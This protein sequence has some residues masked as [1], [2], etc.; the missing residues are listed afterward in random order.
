M[1][2]QL[3]F[4]A[5][6]VFSAITLSAQVSKGDVE[7]FQKYFGAEKAVM[8]KEYMQL[9]PAQ[10]SAFWPI[11]NKYENQRLALGKQRV[12]LIDTYLKNIEGISEIDAGKLVDKGVSLEIAFKNLQKRYFHEMSKKIGPVKAAQFYQFENYLNNVINLSIQES[13]PFVGDLEQRHDALEKKN[14]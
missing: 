12:E 2:K 13:I 11:Y 3:I 14:K 4:I 7:L 10:D 8:L 1:K 9:S 6:M 5:I